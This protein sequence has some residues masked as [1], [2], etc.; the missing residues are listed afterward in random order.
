MS[1]LDRTRWEVLNATADDCENLEQIYLMICRPDR[2]GA[3]PKGGDTPFLFELAASIRQLVDD[4]LL[5][6]VTD[7]NGKPWQKSNDLSYVWRCWFRMTPQ[8]RLAWEQSHHV[9]EQG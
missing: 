5:E 3:G 9:V 1:A 8:G 4:G 6:I 2:N 7:E